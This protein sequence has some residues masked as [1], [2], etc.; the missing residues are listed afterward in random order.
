MD[1]NQVAVGDD[2][3]NK[4]IANLQNRQVTPATIVSNSGAPVVPAGMPGATPQAPAPVP[5][6]AP[7]TPVATPATAPAVIPE[8]AAANPTTVANND[9]TPVAADSDSDSTA[10]TATPVPAPT[11]VNPELEDIKKDAL[12]ELRPLVDRLDLPPE[13]KFDTLLLIIRSTD[14]ASLLPAA[15]TAARQITDDTRRAQALLD[16]IKEIDFFGQSA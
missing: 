12:S 9:V 4:M 8:P 15:H 13:E 7:Q 2:E 3:L 16:V 6:Q 14:D 1:N 5:V 10:P 11:P